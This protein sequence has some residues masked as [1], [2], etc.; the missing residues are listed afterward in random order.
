[1]TGENYGED[2]S[3]DLPVKF[4]RYDMNSNQMAPGVPVYS[5]EYTSAY[6]TAEK[7][8]DV[9]DAFLHFDIELLK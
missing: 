6:I 2:I 1:L 9:D 3:D 5:W 7:Y 4:I 8:H